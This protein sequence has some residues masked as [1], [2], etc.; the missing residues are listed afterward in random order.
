MIRFSP[1]N[2]DLMLALRAADYIGHESPMWLGPVGGGAYVDLRAMADVQLI[3]IRLASLDAVH[4]TA[5]SI[6]LEHNGIHPLGAL[7]SS[8]A[9][10][11]SMLF[12]SSSKGWAATNEYGSVTGRLIED[13][14]PEWD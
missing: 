5:S 13:A 12:K 3:S 9:H 11:I 6:C 8:G 10:D 7:A 14:E 1:K 4:D 2:R